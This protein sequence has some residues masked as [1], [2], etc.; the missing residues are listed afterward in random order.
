LTDID[1]D[2]RGWPEA[3]FLQTPQSFRRLFS[4]RIGETHLVDQSP[5]VW[6]AENAG[7]WIALLSVGGK[8]PELGETEPNLFPYLRELGF[9]IQTGRQS[10]R[11]GKGQPEKLSFQ[12]WVFGLQK[13]RESGQERFG[14]I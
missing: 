3:A 14:K 1:T 9:L 12:S 2:R 13:G 6:V 11:I 10:D 7:R 8:S 5:L 4:P